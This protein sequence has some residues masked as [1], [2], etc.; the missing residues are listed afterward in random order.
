MCSLKTQKTKEQ[1][2]KWDKNQSEKRELPEKCISIASKFS[3]HI[4]FQFKLFPTRFG[5]LLVRR[6]F[7]SI[8]R[9]LS[10]VIRC[11]DFNSMAFSRA[12]VALHWI[13]ER[14]QFVHWHKQREN[15]KD[16]KRFPVNFRQNEA[17]VAEVCTRCFKSSFL[18]CLSPFVLLTH[19]REPKIIPIQLL[20]KKTNQIK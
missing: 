1:K 14:N 15:E 7:F 13:V 17:F 4:E 2:K 12:C 19:K 9:Y 5:S 6:Q 16:N 11:V 10:S 20:R 3:V 8:V 18:F